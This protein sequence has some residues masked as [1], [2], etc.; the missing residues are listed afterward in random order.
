M[1]LRTWNWVIMG[2][3]SGGGLALSSSLVATVGDCGVVVTSTCGFKK[4]AMRQLV[5]EK[6]VHFTLTLFCGLAAVIEMALTMASAGKSVFIFHPLTNATCL[7]CP[8]FHSE[9]R[10]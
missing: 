9:F 8:A 7:L 2:G 10:S 6:Q 1:S 3:L 5:K 4:F